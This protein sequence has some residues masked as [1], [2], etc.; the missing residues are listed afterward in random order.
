MVGGF[1]P[2][3]SPEISNSFNL[4]SNQRIEKKEHVGLKS[5][6]NTLIKWSPFSQ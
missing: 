5:R 3:G 2:L 4:L 1:S 6:E